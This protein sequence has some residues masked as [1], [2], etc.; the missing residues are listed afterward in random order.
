[1]GMDFTNTDAKI[2]KNSQN[3]QQN[4]C[5]V[6]CDRKRK[7][8]C[9]AVLLKCISKECIVIHSCAN[10][11]SYFTLKRKKVPSILNKGDLYSPK[12]ILLKHYGPRFS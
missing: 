11:Y 9:L 5:R 10:P 12:F 2:L 6:I 7:N 3:K 8:V 4:M 1:M